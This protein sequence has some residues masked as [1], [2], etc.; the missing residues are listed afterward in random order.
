LFI[1]FIAFEWSGITVT[2]VWLLIAIIIFTVGVV[3]KWPSLRMASIV[4]MGATLLKLAVFDSLTFS[5][6]QKVISYLSLGVL[7]LVTSYL[8]QKYKQR[9]FDE[10]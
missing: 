5:T 2:L 8:Y 3:K 6:V 7:L 1:V 4:L 10:S 9:L